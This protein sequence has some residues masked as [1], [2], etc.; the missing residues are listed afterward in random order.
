MFRL[1]VISGS[2]YCKEHK[3]TYATGEVFDFPVDLSKVFVN[4]FEIMSPPADSTSP[5]TGGESS[6]PPVVVVPAPVAKTEDPDDFINKL[7]GVEVNDEFPD[8]KDLE[9]VEIRKILKSKEGDKETF[10]YNVID[11][12]DRRI[13]NPS[14]LSKKKTK[15]FLDMLK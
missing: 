1:K 11:K 9:H 4:S 15:A 2:F 8:T 7:M 13:M 6:T 5:A 12:K 14:P 3:R 10:V